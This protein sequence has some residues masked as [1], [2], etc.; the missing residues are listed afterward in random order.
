MEVER[1]PLEKDMDSE[2]SRKMFAVLGVVRRIQVRV[3]AFV[4]NTAVVE[5]ELSWVLMVAQCS[6]VEAANLALAG[7]EVGQIHQ[8][9]DKG[10]TG[11]V[12]DDGSSRTPVDGGHPVAYTVLDD[13]RCHT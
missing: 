5:N 10:C 4:A 2:I 8:G 9:W 12:V 7:V 13:R 1:D 3:A 6:P 11:A